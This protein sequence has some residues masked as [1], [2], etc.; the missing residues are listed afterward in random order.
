[1]LCFICNFLTK[2]RSTLLKSSEPE[3][4]T[5]TI[6]WKETAQFRSLPE[7]PDKLHTLTESFQE[8]NLLQEF[9][10]W[11]MH[12]LPELPQNGSGTRKLQSLHGDLFTTLL[13]CATTT[14]LTR[15]PLWESTLLQMFILRML[16]LC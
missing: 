8:L 7:T 15:E 10:T 4:H 2:I 11:T 12:T 16:D 5:G 14:D 9:H 6:C 13:T 1:M 3:T